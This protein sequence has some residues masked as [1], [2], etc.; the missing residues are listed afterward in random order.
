MLK[1]KV[2]IANVEKQIFSAFHRSA[3]IDASKVHCDV[4]GSTITLRGTVRSYV[5]NK[6]AENAAWNV[7]GVTAVINKLEIKVPEYAFED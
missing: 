7:P 3:T 4:S 6:D 1:P 2:S 5:E